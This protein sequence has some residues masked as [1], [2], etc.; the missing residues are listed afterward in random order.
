ML[1]HELS[2]MLEVIV[3]VMKLC[4]SVNRRQRNSL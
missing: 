4:I 1:Y 3:A 2:L